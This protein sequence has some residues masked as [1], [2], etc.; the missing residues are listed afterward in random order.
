[1][2]KG[3][4]PVH[5]KPREDELLSS[6]LVRLA[7]SHG[8]SPNSFLYILWPQYNFPTDIDIYVDPAILEVLA[9]GTATQISRAT[10]TT[11]HAYENSLFEAE[12]S[13]GTYPWI[14]PIDFTPRNKLFGLQFCPRCL[15]ENKEPYFRRRW[16]L[17]FITIC[18]RHLTPLLD[19]CPRCGSCI[20]SFTS[21]TSIQQNQIVICPSCNVD[22]RAAISP[23]TLSENDPEVKFQQYLMEVLNQG[24]TEIKGSGSVYS[25]L[26]FKVLHS[27]MKLLSSSPSSSSTRDSICQHY[28]IPQISLSLPG[29]TPSLEKLRV[30]ARQSILKMARLWLQDWPDGFIKFWERDKLGNYNFFACQFSKDCNQKEIPFWFWIVLHDFIIGPEHLGWQEMYA[31]SLE[32]QQGQGSW[33]DKYLAVLHSNIDEGLSEELTDEQWAV[34][35]S[36]I[37]KPPQRLVRKGRPRCNPRDVLNA[38][39]WRFRRGA[40][41]QDIP[42]QFPAFQTCYRSF[43][44][45]LRD[46]TLRRVLE[47]LAHNLEQRDDVDLTQGF[48]DGTFLFVGSIDIPQTLPTQKACPLWVWQ[49]FMLLISP[50]TRQLLRHV[51]S[52][53]ADRLFS[54]VPSHS[55]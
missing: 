5:L 26:Y 2:A 19:S 11:L 13:H 46:G 48:I 9:E 4:W 28:G 41:W 8:L 47:A 31:R 37:P 32:S 29:R 12:D 22:L 14:M 25:Q 33:H 34:V 36:L 3:L 24:W 23:S 42:E 18:E 10:A 39:L 20:T 17:A 27:L 45:W 35:E 40:R 1:M 49:T 16:R 38:V 44:Q 7:G 52:P 15:S 54:R 50:S 21:R 30:E 53:L 43:Q 51:K 6:W 55:S